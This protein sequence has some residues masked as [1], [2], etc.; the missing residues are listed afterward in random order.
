LAL[1]ASGR[2]D[3]ARGLVVE[4]AGMSKAIEP[5]V[6]IA[7]VD[8]ICA[9]KEHDPAAVER[10]LQ[11]E[12]VAFGRGALDVLV[13]AYRSTPEILS[14]LLRTSRDGARIRGLLRRIGDD[15]LAAVIGQPILTADDP[16][17]TLSP[18]EREVYELVVQ[19]LT[20]REI[21]RLLFIEESTVKVHVHHIY[22]KLGVRSRL[23]L[24]VQATL[25]RSGQAT[26]AI[27]GPASTEASSS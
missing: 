6:L 3:A 24:I 7:A 11:F 15:D 18:R 5:N 2:T 20:N 13:T 10:V 22:D 21:G 19:R 27:G 8:A 12:Q 4:I 1:A 26:S 16:R 25:E 17:S 14:V 9:L 23:D